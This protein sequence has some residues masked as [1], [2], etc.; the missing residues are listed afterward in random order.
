MMQSKIR[1]TVDWYCQSDLKNAGKNIDRL[2]SPFLYLCLGKV[3]YQRRNMLQS[4]GCSKSF[5]GVLY[6]KDVRLI[7]RERQIWLGFVTTF[8]PSTQNHQCGPSSVCCAY[9]IYRNALIF[10]NTKFSA[11]HDLVESAEVF[12]RWWRFNSVFA[13]M[14]S[15]HIDWPDVMEHNGLN[16]SISTMKFAETRDSMINSTHVQKAETLPPHLKHWE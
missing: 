8:E 14:A 16:G 15:P 12:N 9:S 13:R 7:A 10:R 2:A 3:K 5:G 4:F 11:S 6:D 1:I